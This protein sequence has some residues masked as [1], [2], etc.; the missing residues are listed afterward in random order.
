MVAFQIYLQLGKQRKVGLVED[1]IRVV[2]G[3]KF[4][5]EK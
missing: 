5:G 2:F 1:D 3:K 4:P